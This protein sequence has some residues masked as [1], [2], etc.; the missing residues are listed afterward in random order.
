MLCVQ[1]NI[2]KL[3]NLPA[4]PK[5]VAVQQ[6]EIEDDYYQYAAGGKAE[7]PYASLEGAKK[8]YDLQNKRMNAVSNK[9]GEKML[10]GFSMLS[11]VCPLESCR[12][13][14]LVRQGT[15]PMQCVC[16]DSEYHVSSLGDLVAIHKSP[17]A[18]ATVP[19]AAATTAAASPA[20][21][22]T[23]APASTFTA[24]LATK[25]SASISAAAPAADASF[26]LDMHN[27]PIL[28]LSSFAHDPADASNRISKRLMQGWALLDH[29]CQSAMCRGEVPLM[30][31]LEGKVRLLRLIFRVLF[32]G[33]Q[34]NWKDFFI[35]FIVAMC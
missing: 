23:S 9:L 27:A 4:P 13:T 28:S 21:K 32:Y 24:T 31:D 11:T 15:A 29:C 33:A 18:A 35:V 3:D 20:A 6:F 5:E 34:S 10:A 12:G 7:Q 26:F 22:I 16:C 17:V 2:G 19:A 25:S 14:P 1:A 30:R 8:E